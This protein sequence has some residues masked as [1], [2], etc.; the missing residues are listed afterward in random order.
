MAV[1]TFLH[2]RSAS[3]LETHATLP[4]GRLRATAGIPALRRCALP[5]QKADN[6]PDLYGDC[7]Q[8]GRS[9]KGSCCA[10]HTHALSPLLST[11]PPVAGSLGIPLSPLHA[12]ASIGRELVR[13]S[14]E[15][16]S[17]KPRLRSARRTSPSREHTGSPDR[18]ADRVG[19]RGTSTWCRSVLISS[20]YYKAAKQAL[21]A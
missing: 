7:I 2:R 18:L 11:Q 9:R 6:R 4:I 16:R 20:D 19:V 12:F 10:L 17:S 21:D 5:M 1:Q 13:D 8:C 14:A 15:V 3:E